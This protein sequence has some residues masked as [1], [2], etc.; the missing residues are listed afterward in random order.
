V[1]HD[2]ASSKSVRSSLDVG[3]TRMSANQERNNHHHRL[4]EVADRVRPY[5]TS[6]V[7]TVGGNLGTADGPATATALD[8]NTAL[9]SLTMQDSSR[10]LQDIILAL[11]NVHMDRRIFETATDL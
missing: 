8:R 10:V 3:A 6:G 11:A 7:E 5:Q 4:R 1:R 2:S 9:S